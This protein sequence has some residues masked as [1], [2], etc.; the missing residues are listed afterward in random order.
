MNQ[1]EIF[2][3][4]IKVLNDLSIP[5]MVSGS[6]AVAIYGRPRMTYDMDI[7]VDIKKGDVEKF[8]KKFDENWYCNPE[9]I[10]DAIKR[11]HHFNLIY[12]PLGVKIDF[13]LLKEDE[14]SKEEFNRRREEFFGE[15]LKASFCSPEDVIIKKLEYYK[16]TGSSRHLEDIKSILELYKNLDFSHIEKWVNKKKLKKEWEKIKKQ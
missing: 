16:E 15:N 1:R 8:V 3:Y 10:K 11:K 4:V 6:V 14:F 2:E 5:Y 13:F 9:E 12:I 7:I